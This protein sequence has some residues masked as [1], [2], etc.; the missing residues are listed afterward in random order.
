M[1]PKRWITVSAIKAALV[2]TLLAFAASTLSAA[3]DVDG[4]LH[5]HV[6]F[7][8]GLGVETK[9][10]GESKDGFAIGGQYELQFHENWGVGGIVEFLGQDT[11]R[12]LVL[13]FPVA[14]HPGAGF[15]LFAGPGVEFLPK[16][17]KFLFRVGGG[18]EIHLPGHWHVAPEFFVD[19]IESG[20]N[21]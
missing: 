13:A 3:D 21:N 11:I 5:H 4:Y 14:F 15:R 19:L 12:D 9:D 6:N 1:L 18:F 10:G 17:E 16:G 8:A 20:S 7:F 2:L